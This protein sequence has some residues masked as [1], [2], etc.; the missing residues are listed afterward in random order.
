MW[1]TTYYT[2]F[3][4]LTVV[5]NKRVPQVAVQRQYDA[6]G[7]GVHRH[8]AQF[9]SVSASA[10]STFCCTRVFLGT[11]PVTILILDCCGHLR[12]ALSIAPRTNV[13]QCATF[14][15]HLLQATG[16]KL[17]FSKCVE[18]LISRSAGIYIYRWASELRTALTRLS[19]FI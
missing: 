12:C 7:D 16:N 10:R 8:S 5:C 2:L 14:E 18:R 4:H 19:V 1:R 9:F 3:K 6:A 11:S 17:Y 13:S 15:P